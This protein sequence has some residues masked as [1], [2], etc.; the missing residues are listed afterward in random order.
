MKPFQPGI[1]KLLKRS[2]LTVT[3][4]GDPSKVTKGAMQ[5]LYGTAYGTKFKVYKPKKKEMTV[6]APS[7]FWLDAHKKPRS[8]WTAK[9]MLEVPAFVKQKDLVQKVSSTPVKVASLPAMTV[10]EILHLGPY[11]AEGPTI[12]KLHAFIKAQKLRIAGPHEEVYL[13]RPGPKAKTI[14]RY[15][16]KKGT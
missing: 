3:T 8:K 15:R 11:S 12:K 4:V 6:G 10:A 1:T 9:W 16:V 13:S 14:I 7:A 2:V 5:A